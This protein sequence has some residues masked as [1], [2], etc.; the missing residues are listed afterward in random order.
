M[1]RPKRRKDKYNPYTLIDNN[2]L[3]FIDSRGNRQTIEVSEELYNEFNKFELQDKKMMNEYDRHIEH[4]DTSVDLLYHMYKFKEP[5]L[6]D[7]FIRRIDY[8]NIHNQIRKL[9]DIQ[10]RRLIMYYFKNMTLDQISKIDRCSPR[11]VKYSIDIA[12]KKLSKIYFKN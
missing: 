8:E 7:E 3:T 10:R 4:S 5:T 6:E 2:R 11:A 9:P 1:K 12:I